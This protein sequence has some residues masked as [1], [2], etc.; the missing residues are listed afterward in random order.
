MD[1]GNN[2]PG[3]RVQGE[4]FLVQADGTPRAQ[5]E[6]AELAC[7]PLQPPHG[8][9]LAPLSE[10]DV[11]PAAA[12]VLRSTAPRRRPPHPHADA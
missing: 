9:V 6:I 5:V 2:E 8:V 7:I 12:R 3:R 10:R 1:G 4:S 11:L